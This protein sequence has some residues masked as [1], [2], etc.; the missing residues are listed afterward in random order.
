MPKTARPAVRLDAGLC[1]HGVPHGKGGRIKPRPQPYLYVPH[2]AEQDGM[3]ER[4]GRGKRSAAS[5]AQAAYQPTCLKSPAP[6]CFSMRL[7]SSSEGAATPWT[8]AR[9][10]YTS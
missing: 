8:L 5:A 7:R 6:T 9:T 3:W 4:R 2:S 10:A 1:L